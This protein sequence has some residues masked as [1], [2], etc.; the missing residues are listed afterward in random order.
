MGFPER[1]PSVIDI[2]SNSLVSEPMQYSHRH[3]DTIM[4]ESIPQALDTM[5]IA[6]MPHPQMAQ[7]HYNIQRG[8]TLPPTPTQEV[9]YQEMQAYTI[10]EE[11]V[12]TPSTVSYSYDTTGHLSQRPAPYPDWAIPFKPDDV[13]PPQLPSQRYSSW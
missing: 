11:Q 12:Y 8:N 10:P 9:P 7:Q 1:P 5:S 13:W 6:D 3:P 4:H 2:H